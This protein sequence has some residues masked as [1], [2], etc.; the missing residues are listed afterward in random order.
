M[1]ADIQQL[2]AD[3]LELG[4]YIQIQEALVRSDETTDR[5]R[6]PQVCADGVLCLLAKREEAVD[7]YWSE[8][9]HGDLALFGESHRAQ[10]LPD[11]VI[12][13][14]GLSTTP[15]IDMT[16]LDDELWQDVRR[17]IREAKFCSNDDETCAVLRLSTYTETSELNDLG[18]SLA[19]IG[20]AVRAAL[21]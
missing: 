3:E 9:E 15:H 4:K 14:A 8:D 7:V 1:R 19:T 16:R 13:W 5:C 20:R 6:P 17:E 21:V 18:V 10:L 11:E 2:W 12:D